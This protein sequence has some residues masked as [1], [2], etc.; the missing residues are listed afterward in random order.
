M[1]VLGLV[2]LVA[3]PALLIYLAVQHQDTL[4]PLVQ[5]L[6]TPALPTAPSPLAYWGLT[7]LAAM[8]CATPGLCTLA[9]GRLLRRGG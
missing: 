7:A 2:L 4:A 1:V 3:L 9:L 6:L 8:L 5:A